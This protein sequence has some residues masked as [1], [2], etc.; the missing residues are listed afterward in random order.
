[1]KILINAIHIKHYGCGI[2]AL[3]PI[4]TMWYGGPWVPSVQCGIESLE[5]HL[6]HVV[7]W[8]LCPISTTWYC[9]P[10]VPSLPRGIASLESHLY[11]VV[12]WALSP[13]SATWYCEPWVPTLP[14]GI[15]KDFTLFQ[16][17]PEI[18][19]GPPNLLFNGYRGLLPGGKA[20]GVWSWKSTPY[21]APRLKKE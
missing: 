4:C 10:W 14:R 11:H 9:K 8:A 12:L 5:S 16:E 19:W 6:H 15:A 18:F 7:L 2:G 20:A 17:S 3:G 21:V 1:M 13:I